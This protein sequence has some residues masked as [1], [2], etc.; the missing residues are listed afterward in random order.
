[1]LLEEQQRISLQLKESRE[2]QIDLDST[3]TELQAKLHEVRL[4]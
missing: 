1:M 2:L 3:E 4:L